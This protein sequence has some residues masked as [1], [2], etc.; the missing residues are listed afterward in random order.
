MTKSLPYIIALMILMSLASR[1]EAETDA[2]KIMSNHIN[3]Q[4][5]VLNVL[6]QQIDLQ[7]LDLNSYNTDRHNTPEYIERKIA[8]DSMVEN[9]NAQV[10]SHNRQIDLYKHV[11]ERGTKK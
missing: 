10:A 5:P 9:Y 4:V 6:R 1:S 8:Y 2:C 11:C 3:Q 7:T